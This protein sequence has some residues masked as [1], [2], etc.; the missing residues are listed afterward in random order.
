MCGGRVQKNKALRTVVNKLDTIDNE[1]RNFKMEVLAG[2]P[3]FVVETVSPHPCRPA[4][5]D[6]T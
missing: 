2:D 1:F 6:P 3:D 5:R 4:N